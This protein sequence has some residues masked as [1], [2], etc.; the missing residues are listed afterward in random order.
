VLI[1]DGRGG[2]QPGTNACY[3]GSKRAQHFGTEIL[4]AQLVQPGA[5]PNNDVQCKQGMF[6]CGSRTVDCGSGDMGVKP[7]WR[8]RYARVGLSQPFAIS[9]AA[10]H[11][12]L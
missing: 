3:R 12:Y 1:A 9:P 2:E 5:T 10:M 8:G 11:G 7:G 4:G 6:F